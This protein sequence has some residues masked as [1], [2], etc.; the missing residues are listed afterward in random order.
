MSILVWVIGMLP[1]LVSSFDLCLAYDSIVRVLVQPFTR[2][3]RF[4]VR[5]RDWSVMRYVLIVLAS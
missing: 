1:A 2:A 4:A 3:G 5:E